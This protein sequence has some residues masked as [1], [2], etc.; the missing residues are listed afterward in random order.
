MKPLLCPLQRGY[1]NIRV[2]DI[3]YR[4]PALFGRQAV[5]DRYVD[6][7]AFTLGVPRSMLNVTAAAKG[8]VAGA[9]EICRRD[10]SVVSASSDREGILVPGLR[11]VLSVTMNA[12]KWVLVVEKE[13]RLY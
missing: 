3:Y 8:L 2:R 7:V 5:V 6:D 13:V 11:D 9:F 12:V 10:G 4:D 1:T